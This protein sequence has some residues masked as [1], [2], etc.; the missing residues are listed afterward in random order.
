M[1]CTHCGRELKEESL[2][3]SWCGAPVVEEADF[4]NPAPAPRRKKKYPWIILGCVLIVAAAVAAGLILKN[5]S[6]RKATD[7]Y[8]DLMFQDTDGDGVDDG[9]ETRIGSD[10]N[11]AETEFVTTEKDGEIKEILPVS[12]EVSAVTD[13]DGAGTLSIEQLTNPNQPALMACSYG[14]IAPAYDLSCEGELD[15]AV[16][17]FSYDTALASERNDFDPTIYWYDEVNDE[18]VEVEGQTKENGKVSAVVTHFSIY[19]L[20]DKSIIDKIIDF[21]PDFIDESA[22]LPDENTDMIPDIYAEYINEG[23]LKYSNT[24][25]LTG[26]LDIFGD[27]DDW[28]GDGLKNG[29]EIGFKLYLDRKVKIV[30]HS[31]PYF[32][33]TDGDGLDDYAEVR[34]LKTSPLRYDR[35]SVGAYNHLLN[36][37]DYLYSSHK[38]DW[39]DGLAK[40]LDQDKKKQAKA[41]LMDF[42][43]KYAPEDSIKKNAEEIAKQTEY[44]EFVKYVGAVGDLIGVAK[45]L[46][47]M[48]NSVNEAEFYGTDAEEKARELCGHQKDLIKLRNQSRTDVLSSSKKFLKS[49][50]E[51]GDEMETFV[52]SDMFQQFKGVS[53]YF[54]LISN[55]VSVYSK[56]MKEHVFSLRS[57]MESYSRFVKNP[58]EPSKL[59]GGT[60]LTVLCDIADGVEEITK[61]IGTYSQMK[62][63]ADAYLMF[64]ELLT[65]IRANSEY[66]YVA[67]AAGDIVK[68]VLNEDTNEYF[69]Q[70]LDECSKTILGTAGTIALD[71]LSKNPY[72]AAA[73]ALIEGYKA[74]GLPDQAESDIYFETMME[75]SENCRKILNRMV[76]T[77]TQTFSYYEYDTANVDKYLIQLAQSRIIGEQYFY[78]YCAKDNIANWVSSIF[79]GK[80]P[81]SY[82]DLFKK[83][84]G[85]IYDYT[86]R[87]HLKLS[88]NLPH[89]DLYYDES[90]QEDNIRIPLSAERLFQN[91]AGKYTINS[92]NE[93]WKTE[94]ILFENGYFSGIYRAA[95]H[96]GSSYGKD[97]ETLYSER[98]F[99]GRFSIG[100]PIGDYAFRLVL[101]D[102]YYDGVEG[103][104]YTEEVNGETIRY[105]Y[106]PAVGIEDV[107]DFVLYG[108]DTPAD[109]VDDTFRDFDYFLGSGD[110]DEMLHY[111]YRSQV[112]FS[113]LGSYHF[114]KAERSGAITVTDDSF[115]EES[116]RGEDPDN[117]IE[118]TIDKGQLSL[119]KNE[120][121]LRTKDMEA[122]QPEFHKDY[123]ISRFKLNGVE[124]YAEEEDYPLTVPI[125]PSSW[126]ADGEVYYFGDEEW[127]MDSVRFEGDNLIISI[128]TFESYNVFW[129]KKDAS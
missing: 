125:N 120:K 1:K 109:A 58:A 46:H 32:S 17:T 78:E 42:L 65:S 79:S 76:R 20:I 3:C 59:K 21:L 47:S 74:S 72:G 83:R 64:L 113:I 63:N 44:N 27:S 108:P 111:F 88:K 26:V 124:R 118:V 38:D 121:Y 31:N 122:E 53:A 85:R 116:D 40:A 73:K 82:M 25:M 41:C 10:P 68:V 61:I 95:G 117:R 37:S 19:S 5:N 6:G 30:V 13:A 112:D 55:G 9:T 57:E 23:K 98:V 45:D 54:S 18:F 22:L 43:Y 39:S 49:V 101:E 28:D 90:V 69:M 60:A 115:V 62:A 126:W 128:Y 66:E 105:V 51:F 56:C 107:T 89:F 87:L 127:N 99:S 16:L 129:F 100:D 11:H 81:D 114:W 8:I 12:I 75:V 97:G 48:A 80:S 50:K 70:L 94:L 2:F 34:Q 35:S 91:A 15:S 52:G 4:H 104:S 67:S 84:V 7:N 33:D 93:T 123:I 86:N 92:F 110:E 102:Y 96:D 77:S 24:G 71:L 106:T 119:T 29:E 103:D 14:Y 36:H